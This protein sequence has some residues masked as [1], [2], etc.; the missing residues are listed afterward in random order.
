[1]AAVDPIAQRC[2]SEA[3]A[4]VPEFA[5]VL[6]R[7]GGGRECS[8]T[9]LSG[10]ISNHLFLVCRPGCETRALVRIYGAGE[11]LCDRSSEEAL[12][13]MLSA[14]GFGLGSVALSLRIIY[15]SSSY[16]NL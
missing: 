8:A 6:Q 10:G 11:P 5:S 14:R 7:H 15:S 12:V 16:Q 13:K 4:A 3:V 2:L 9:R 1:M